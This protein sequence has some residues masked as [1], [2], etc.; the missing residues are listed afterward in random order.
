MIQA[1]GYFG[2]QWLT[3]LRSCI[4]KDGCT[5]EDWIASVVLPMYKSKGN[6]MECSSYRWKKL[7]ENVIRVVERVFEHRIGQQIETG[8][9][10][11]SFIKSK[12]MIGATF[13]IRQMQKKFTEN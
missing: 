8:D 12:A 5:P 7:L 2:I 10:Q 1:S 4:V 9:M 13:V 6:S 11:F 3:D